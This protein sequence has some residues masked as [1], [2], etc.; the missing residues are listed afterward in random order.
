MARE[1]RADNPEYAIKIR[2]TKNNEQRII[3][4]L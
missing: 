4:N 1:Y 3:E 2:I